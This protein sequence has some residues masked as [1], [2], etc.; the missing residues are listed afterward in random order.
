MNEQTYPMQAIRQL[1][2]D[3]DEAQ[4]AL[5]RL[6]NAQPDLSQRE[7]SHALGLSL[8]KTHYVLHALLDRGLVKVSNFRRNDNKLG[9]AYFLTPTGLGEKIN[10]TRRF[11]AR[12]ETEFEQLQLA[13]AALR[14]ELADK[15]LPAKSRP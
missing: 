10:M 11:L 8:G 4:L 3:A 1:Q 14:A 12:K 13:I 15:A 5:L 9:Y 7:L 6:L 2:P